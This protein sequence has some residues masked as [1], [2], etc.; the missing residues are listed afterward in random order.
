MVSVI[1]M[2][3]RVLKKGRKERYVTQSMF[4]KVMGVSDF[5]WVLSPNLPLSTVD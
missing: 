2:G 3:E 1:K 4:G 5:L